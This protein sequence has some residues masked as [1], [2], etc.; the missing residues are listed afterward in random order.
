MLGCI[1][2]LIETAEMADAEYLVADDRPQLQL[3]LRGECKRAFRAHQKMRHVVGRI[4]RHQRIQIVASDSPL[5]FWKLFGDL[6]GFA[7]AEIEHV[8]KQSKPGLGW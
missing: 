6:G 2:S 8:A 4:P 1:H 7:F 3:D 5:Q